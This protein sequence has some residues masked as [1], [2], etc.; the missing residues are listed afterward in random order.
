MHPAFARKPLA[1]LL[2]LGLLTTGGLAQ[3]SGF[4]IP[5]VST[6]GLG[7]SNALVANP[8][9]V[10]ALPYNPAA[11]AF[12]EGTNLSAGL[13]IIEPSTT[14]TNSTGSH[15][16]EP[17]TPFYVPNAYMMG[18]INPDLTWGVGVTAPFGLQTKWAPG[19]FP[20]SQVAAATA[21]AII[22]AGGSPAQAAAAAQQI[23]GAHP[24]FSK[25]EM[26]NFNPNVA[27][28][29][30]SNLS[31][32]A[33]VDYYL[34]NDLNLNTLGADIHGDGDGWGFNL[35]A[36]YS[37]G[38]WSLGASYRSAVT[39]DV[40]GSVDISG[41]ATPAS[42]TVDFPSILQVGVRYQASEA[43][44]LEFDV[45]RTGWSTFDRITINRT[46]TT[47]IV[48]ANN[49]DDANAYRLGAT[50]DLR[51]NTQL[52]FGY[53]FDETPQPDNSFSPRVPDNDRQLFS[54]G[55]AQNM[56]G[57][58]VEAGYMYVLVDDRTIN[59]PA[60]NPLANSDP[61][62]TGVFNGEYETDIHLLALGVSTKF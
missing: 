17:S 49:W 26:L 3:A 52:R 40:D 36:L 57:W 21:A 14:V 1:G 34:I 23:G 41:T 44:A 22:G 42:T 27:Y 38:P 4:R 60:W 25:I 13:A 55:V 51:P 50:Y 62:G 37:A 56:S 20:F 9:E 32:S 6:A 29:I 11:M 39:A 24:T 58:T 10:G 48:S 54:I 8:K 31:V 35:A 16:S 28:K 45:D 47:P 18:H 2:S 30:G 43:L 33:G 61:N 46:G 12:H 59:Q 15:D 53:T 19:T 7:T 5:E